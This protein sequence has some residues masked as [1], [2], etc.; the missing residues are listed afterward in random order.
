[1][2]LGVK[3]GRILCTLR[4]IDSTLSNLTSLCSVVFR[5]THAR[6]RVDCH[7]L[8]LRYY[9]PHAPNFLST[10]T[11]PSITVKCHRC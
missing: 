3:Q 11:S 4:F 9:I 6:F 2:V 8:R 7:S 5:K 1:M 10:P